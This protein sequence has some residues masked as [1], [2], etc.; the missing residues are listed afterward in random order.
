META[1]FF[2][3]TAQYLAHRFNKGQDVVLLPHNKSQYYAA[4]G[5]RGALSVAPSLPLQGRRCAQRYGYKE[6]E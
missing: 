6:V 5:R 4:D 2:V 1:V 3:H